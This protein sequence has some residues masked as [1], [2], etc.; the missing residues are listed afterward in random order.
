MFWWRFIACMALLFGVYGMAM[1]V[2]G[3]RQ[4][5]YI[6]RGLELTRAESPVLFWFLNIGQFLCGVAAVVVAINLL[7]G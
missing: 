7:F 2:I 4:G 5:K 1:T 6:G 3:F